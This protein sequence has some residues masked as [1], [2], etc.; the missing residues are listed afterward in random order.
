MASI[1]FRVDDEPSGGNPHDCL[2]NLPGVR[3]QFYPKAS[4]PSTIPFLAG[5]QIGA[6]FLN[7]LPDSQLIKIVTSVEERIGPRLPCSRNRDWFSSLT[8]AQRI[9]E[10]WPGEYNES[11]PHRTLGEKSPNEFADEIAT[12]RNFLGFQTAENFL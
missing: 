6:K 2:V 9:V 3:H 7:A 5:C 12:S 10:T 1:Q 4:N 11:H 8:E